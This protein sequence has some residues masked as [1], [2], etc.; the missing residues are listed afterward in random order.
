[1][2]VHADGTVDCTGRNRYAHPTSNVAREMKQRSKKS[3]RQVRCLEDKCPRLPQY[4]D[5]LLGEK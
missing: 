3:G 4:R 1:L 5:K 2:L